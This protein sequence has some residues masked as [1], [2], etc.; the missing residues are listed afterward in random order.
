[1]ITIGS[2]A[3]A[4]CSGLTSVTIPNNVT[5]IG[6]RAF[7]DCRGI[8]SL[9]IGSSVTSIGGSAF[10]L[11]ENLTTVTIPSSVVEIGTGAFNQCLRLATVTSMAT[12]P[13]TMGNGVFDETAISS[14][15]VPSG[16]VSAYRAADGWKK[17]ANIITAI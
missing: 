9:T 5:T 11:C 10:N 16:S 15:R 2:D 8:R 3:F 12:T 17:Y 13:P 14:I 6:S 7:Y 4:Y 1:M